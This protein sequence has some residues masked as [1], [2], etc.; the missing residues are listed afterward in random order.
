MT[1][2]H[3][4]QGVRVLEFQAA[5]PVPFCGMLLAD[6]GAEVLVVG[7][8]TNEDQP[9]AVDP[10]K[11]VLHRGKRRI[12]LDLKS[13]EGRATALDLAAR[14]D[15]VLEGLRPGVMERI[16]LGPQ[17]L[18]GQ[19]PDLVYARVSGYGRDGP[20]A[21]RPGH[22]LNFLAESGAL[23]AMGDAD[24]VPS[25]P[26]NL[27]ADFGGAGGL[28]ATG[29]LGA[30]LHA[31]STG[32]GQVVDVSMLQAC[33]VLMASI[34]SWRASGLW[35]DERGTNFLD[36][37]CPWY[38]VYRAQDGHML[39]VASLEAP[40][41]ARLLDVLA[42]PDFA[43]AQWDRSRWPAMAA[44][45]RAVFASRPRSHWIGKFADAP[46]CVSPVVPLPDEPSDGWFSA[47]G[48]LQPRSAI[49]ARGP[50]PAQ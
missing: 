30:L 13:E 48:V 25:P 31:R 5:G 22:D 45:M 8:P 32:Q 12:A 11:D 44:C 34:C 29:V 16:G 3:W 17:V 49:L 14:A 39:A 43:D 50:H 4:L 24:R 18:L 41:Y 7:R 26:L 35:K 9:Y 42:L 23:Y 46:A 33:R 47:A 27:V 2:P 1:T 40:F 15:A 10:E 6:M 20:D 21:Q 28:A 37:S 38:A 19:K 36:G